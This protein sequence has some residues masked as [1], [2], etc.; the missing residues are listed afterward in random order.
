MQKKAAKKVPAISFPEG[1]AASDSI[2]LN[3]V[4]LIVC[5]FFLFSNRVTFV[6]FTLYTSRRP[7]V[8]TASHFYH[9]HVWTEAC[10]PG[11]FKCNPIDCYTHVYSERTLAA[12]W[13]IHVDLCHAAGEVSLQLSYKHTTSQQ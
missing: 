7:H 12:Q 2:G 13:C 5:V 1:G 10:E 6:T 3:A 8:P 11:M 9:P 4:L